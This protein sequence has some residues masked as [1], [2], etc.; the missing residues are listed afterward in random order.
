MS[1]IVVK[2]SGTSSSIL[3]EQAI[4]TINGVNVDFQTSIRYVPDTL[5]VFLNGLRERYIT[6]LGDKDFRFDVAPVSG[7]IVDVEYVPY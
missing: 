7:D 3:K 2:P 6:Q 4:G 5:S 1:V